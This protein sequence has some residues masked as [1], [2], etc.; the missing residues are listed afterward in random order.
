MGKVL[1]KGPLLLSLFTCFKESH[2]ETQTRYFL[3]TN[4]HEPSV[5]FML[6][7]TLIQPFP[8]VFASVESQLPTEPIKRGIIPNKNV[9]KFIGSLKFSWGEETDF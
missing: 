4:L 7:S 3:P 8:Q 9:L 6:N 2:Q 1:P 5:T